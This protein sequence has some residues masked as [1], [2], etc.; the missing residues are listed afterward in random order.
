VPRTAIHFY[1]EKEGGDVPFKTWL[2][3][4]ARQNAKAHKKCLTYLKHLQ[5]EG[6]ELKRPTADTLRNG[7]YELR[8]SYQGVNYRILYGFAGQGL[9]VV[10]H[11]ITKEKRVPRAEIDRAVA[12]LAKYKQNPTKHA[13]PEDVID[14]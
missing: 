9:V 10:S 13:Y 4:L 1:R 8:P 7:I 12:R 3:E 5:Q 11:G 6:H 14:G 2:K